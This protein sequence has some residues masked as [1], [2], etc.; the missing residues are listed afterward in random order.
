MNANALAIKAAYDATAQGDVAK[1]IEL[2]TDDVHWRATGPGPLA[3]L[4]RGKQ[5]RFLVGEHARAR[6]KPSSAAIFKRKHAATPRH[7]VDDEL[8]MAPIFKLSARDE[9]RCAADGAKLHVTVPGQEI[10]LPIAHR[11]R[12]IATT[13]RLVE[14]HG[15]MRTHQI[16]DQFQGSFGRR[17]TAQVRFAHGVSCKAGPP[18]FRPEAPAWVL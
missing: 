14:Q 16:A 1:L 12:A 10:A 11:R 13:T 18:G 2:L 4:Y 3:G 17:H 7:D 15:P 8:G 6:E 9:E 5:S